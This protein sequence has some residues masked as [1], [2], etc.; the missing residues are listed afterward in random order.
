MFVQKWEND[1]LV[2]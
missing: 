2:L 1:G